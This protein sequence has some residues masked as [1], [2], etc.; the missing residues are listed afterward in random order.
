MAEAE[1]LVVAE[2]N[3]AAADVL[4]TQLSVFRS[5]G[6]YVR[7]KLYEKVAPR[8]ESVLTSDAQGTILGLPVGG[9]PAARGGGQPVDGGPRQ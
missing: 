5:D 1:R 7:S 6:D 9:A 8:I 3:R 2:G 4:K